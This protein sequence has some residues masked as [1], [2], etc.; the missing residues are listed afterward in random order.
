MY[1]SQRGTQRSL[2]EVDQCADFLLSAAAGRS[3]LVTGD[4]PRR[5][6]QINGEGGAA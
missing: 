5:S 1:V 3:I 2:F 4:A 6:K